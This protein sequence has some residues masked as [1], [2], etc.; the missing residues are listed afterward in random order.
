M[1]SEFS[2]ENIDFWWAVEDYRMASESE[3]EKKANIIFKTF[4]A[5]SAARAVSICFL[6]KSLLPYYYLYTLFLFQLTLEIMWNN[7]EFI[8]LTCYL[9]YRFV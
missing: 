8:K 2:D 4:V 1:R 5:K 9:E 6:F 3:L 7:V